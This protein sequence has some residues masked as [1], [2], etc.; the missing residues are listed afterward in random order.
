MH[1]GAP[2]KGPYTWTAQHNGAP[3]S[4][5]IVSVKRTAIREMRRA[6]K[7]LGEGATGDVRDASGSLVRQVEAYRTAGGAVKVRELEL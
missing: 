1:G 3:G 2:V 5:D 4:A 7:Q 6:V